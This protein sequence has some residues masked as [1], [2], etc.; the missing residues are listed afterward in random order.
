VLLTVAGIV[1]LPTKTQAYTIQV[2]Y[3][4]QEPYQTQEAYTIQVPYQTQE[5]YTGYES[6]TKS[7]TVKENDCDYSNSCTCTQTSWFGLGSTCVECSCTYQE[8]VPTTKYQTVTKYKD[9]T[10]YRTVTKYRD[11]TKF[12]DETRYRKVNWIFGECFYNC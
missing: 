7:K 5:A 4:D 8:S 10:R 9:E 11:V 6:V 3:T 12:R 1:F 2:P